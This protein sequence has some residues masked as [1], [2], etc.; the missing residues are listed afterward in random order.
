M[1]ILNPER[2]REIKHIL[3]EY[4]GGI[5]P[6]NNIALNCY[7]TKMPNETLHELGQKL[8]NDMHIKTKG[9]KHR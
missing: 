7:N 8:Y 5:I 3:R 2:L 4:T 1:K 9:A 6:I